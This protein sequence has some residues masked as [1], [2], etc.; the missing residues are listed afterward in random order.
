MRLTFLGAAGTVTGSRTLV[1]GED[2]YVM[3]DCG[4]FQGWKELRLQNRQPFGIRIDQLDAVVLTHA[5]LDHSGACSLLVREGYQG[6]IHA[7][8]AT[9]DLCQILWRDAA[10]LQE[11]DAERANRKGYSRHHPALP[12]FDLRD[13]ERAID[14]LH[15]ERL[16]RVYD[17]R[18]LRFTHRDAGH[19]LG[20]SSV[21]VENHRRR[22]L[23]SGD[24]GRAVDPIQ[25]SPEPL[26]DD[27]DVL[28]LESTYGDRRHEAV[29]PEEVLGRIVRETVKRGGQV[30]VPTFAV[31]RV[32]RLLHHLAR[33]KAAERIPDVPIY[34]NSPL[35][36]AAQRVFLD[37]PESHRLTDEE[38]RAIV[39]VVTVVKTTEE[40]KRLTA[41][42]APAVIL[43]GAG[44]V[45]GG[46]I[47]HHLAAR[48]EDSRSTV[49]LVGFQ[50][51]GT[52]GDRLLKGETT[53]RMFGQD[54]PVLAHVERLDNLSAHADQDE[55][56]TWL[57]T[58]RRPPRRVILNHGE[59]T[60][61]EALAQRITAE[62]GIP[63]E[64]ATM[65]GV[66]EV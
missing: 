25:G 48:L 36:D 45:T 46:R 14:R 38:V 19:I 53:L 30:L 18:D 9:A 5:H 20:A 43:A 16:H 58:A 47:L 17:V 65:R 6:P 4:L 8:D 11:E 21:L 49:L 2:A 15:V 51:G 7:T 27:L 37:H 28:V 61:S 32:Q 31:G 60:A 10:Y 59:P 66:V 12:L 54:V 39:D 1:R 50:A 57:G 29:D 56:M 35:A 23:F 33:L 22:V 3:V 40:S 42:K 24:V 26:P 55:L 52:R 13:A 64:V 44:M 34:L 41:S 63:A 62:T